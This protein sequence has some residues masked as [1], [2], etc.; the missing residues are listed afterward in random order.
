M[1]TSAFDNFYKNSVFFSLLPNKQNRNV[2]KFSP[3]IINF[4]ING[5]IRLETSSTAINTNFMLIKVKSC[6]SLL[7]TVKVGTRSW[8]RFY[9]E[10]DKCYGVFIEIYYLLYKNTSDQSNIITL[11]RT[12]DLTEV[13]LVLFQTTYVEGKLFLN[14]IK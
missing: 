12:A 4:T 9:K 13:G 14:D 5:E 6:I 11:F 7:E 8:N 3:T 2:C 1:L 10:N